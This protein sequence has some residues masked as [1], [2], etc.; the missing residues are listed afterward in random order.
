MDHLD[1]LTGL[2]I[3]LLVILIVILL[4]NFHYLSRNKV[5]K[6]QMSSFSIYLI[7]SFLMLVSMGLS[8]QLEDG[9]LY[10]LR[11]IP[12]LLGGIYGGR[13]VMP[14]LAVTMVAI[15]LPMM[16][17]GV[18]ITMIIA[19]LFTAIILYVRPRLE[20]KA[21]KARVYTYSALSFGYSVL[22][23]WLPSV[24]FDFGELSS[25]P[26]YSAV[27]TGSTFF[28]FYLC[29]IIRTIYILQL[30][31]IKYE[32]MQVVSHL[33]A[34]M[35]HEVRNPLTT[36]RGFL[37]LIN[38]DPSN[39]TNNKELSEVAVSEIDR[40]TEVI[41]QYLNFARPH[42]E[43]EEEVAIRDEINRSKEIIMPLSIKKGI[44]LKANILHHHSIKGDP[45][46]LQQVLINVM[47]NGLEAMENGG[48]LRIFSYLENGKIFIVIND[49][50]IGM[51]KEQL[52]RLGEP[53]FS[54]KGK[55]GTGLGMMTVYQL[56]EGMKGTIKVLSKPG[57]GT[58]VI[59]SFPPYNK[60]E[61]E[62][63]STP[64]RTTEVRPSLR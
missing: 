35:S 18:I 61:E 41:N 46:K 30:K 12:F 24:I 13:K 16:G 50:G 55:N 56:V 59:L 29:E 51:T 22:S 63:A 4:L 62:T 45:N 49:T 37:Q 38:E 1:L 44:T 2:L 28:V 10:D 40:A 33:A 23:F 43:L 31:S 8:V 36:V 26:I 25:F 15:R 58:S 19:I 6:L 17:T 9:F 48:T 27:L 39:I 52:M 64:A 60:K 21:L 53:Y 7:S 5:H 20:N 54:M 32:K 14:W 34:S 11:C 47:K 57:K 42:P 3:N